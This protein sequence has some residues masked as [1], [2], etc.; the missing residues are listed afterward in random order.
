M[1]NGYFEEYRI[2][3][4]LAHLGLYSAGWHIS[5]PFPS[6]SLL[7]FNMEEELR[8]ASPSISQGPHSLGTVVP[9]LR[10]VRKEGERL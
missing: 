5:F 10:R 9:G 2:A 3:G 8:T 6:L 7:Y 1:V 4:D